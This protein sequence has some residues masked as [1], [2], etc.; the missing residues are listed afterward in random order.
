MA[1]EYTNL[2]HSKSPQNL[3]EFGFLVC[4]INHLATLLLMGRCRTTPR[5]RAVPDGKNLISFLSAARSADFPIVIWDRCYDF[6]IYFRRKIQ[7]KIGVF[8]SKQS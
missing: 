5:C 4:K 3:P 7:Q 8:D 1:I 2:F 6:L